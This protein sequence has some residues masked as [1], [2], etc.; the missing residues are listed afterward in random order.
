MQVLNPIRLN[1]KARKGGPADARYD[2]L[3]EQFGSDMSI[4]TRMVCDTVCTTV[5]KA[6]V[7]CMVRTVY[8]QSPA[9]GD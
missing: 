7:H 8:A 3:M 5:P 2:A 9:S 6:I 4:Y 1:E